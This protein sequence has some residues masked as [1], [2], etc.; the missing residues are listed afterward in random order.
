LHALNSVI[1]RQKKIYKQAKEADTDA[2]TAGR[3]EEYSSVRTQATLQAQPAANNPAIIGLLETAA[4][5]MNDAGKSEAA[6]DAVL[7]QTYLSL[8]F[9]LGIQIL[10][11]TEDMSDD[12]DSEN[13]GCC[14]CR[15]SAV[16]HCIVPCGH[17][18]ICGGCV[19]A[20]IAL[21]TPDGGGKSFACPTCRED[22]STACKVYT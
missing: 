2:N 21:A 20:L 14:V 9:S 1:K 11:W 17:Q 22:P 8:A 19:D 15:A 6:K 18:N 13:V 3:R 5:V 12:E 4:S 10:P 16:T 7:R